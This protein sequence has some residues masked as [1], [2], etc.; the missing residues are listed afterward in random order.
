[1][2]ALVVSDIHSN[3]EALQTVLGDSEAHGGFDTLWCLG[4]MVGYGPDPNECIDLIRSHPHVAIAGNHDLA[5]L[6]AVGLEVFNAN[7]AEAARWT[8]RQLSQEQRDYLAALPQ[9]LESEGVTLVH[10]SPLDTTW[11][12]FLPAY[13]GQQ[14]LRQSFDEI[15]TPWCLVGHS[16]IPFV[17]RESDLSFLTPTEGQ[18]VRVDQERLVL[19]PGSVGQP[20]DGDPRAAYGLYD[21]EAATFVH[22]RVAYDIGAVQ[23]K[24]QRAGLPAA[25][26]ER[27]S[28]GR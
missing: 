20:R 26:A 6:S 16:H 12:Y 5:A 11:G 22:L 17:C 25:L 13:M 19:N 23:A 9:R 4:D 18:P 3:L 24:M 14:E 27:L 21:A 2:R 15:E 28:R 7:A 1:M 8:G 10:G